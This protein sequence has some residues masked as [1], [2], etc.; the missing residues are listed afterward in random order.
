[1][2]VVQVDL[3]HF[4][5]FL[6]MKR[7]AG[8]ADA[9]SLLLAPHNV[10]GPVGTMANLHLRRGHAELQGAGTLQRFC[11]RVGARPGRSFAAHRSARRVL[12]G[13]DAA[14]AR[15]ETQ[16]RVSAASIPA[17]AGA[18][19]CSRKGGKGDARVDPE[20]VLD[21]RAE[22]GEGPLW[23]DRRQRLHVRRYHCAATSTSSIPQTRLRPRRPRGPARRLRRAD[24]KR[25]TGSSAPST[26]SIA[27]I[28][29]PAAPS[30]SPPSKP[31]SQTRA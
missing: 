8:W 19:V 3:T 13:A 26:V 29:A 4:G 6:A 20:L 25:A 17:P 30:S 2:D 31:I 12:R 10:C 15:A 14:G 22:L 9:Y 1:M 21:A 5:G 18:S 28:P 27:S 11:R 7:L 16:S 23:D 24:A